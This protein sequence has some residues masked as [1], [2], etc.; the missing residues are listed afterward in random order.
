MATAFLTNYVQIVA[1]QFDQQN[2][3]ECFLIKISR[4]RFNFIVIAQCN[5]TKCSVQT[6]NQPTNPIHPKCVNKW[7]MMV[8][9]ILS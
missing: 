6:T 5:T 2:L 7:V 9:L 8:M 1:L 3:F 4:F